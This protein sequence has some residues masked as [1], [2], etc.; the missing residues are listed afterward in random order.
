MDLPRSALSMGIENRKP[1]TRLVAAHFKTRRLMQVSLEN[2]RVAEIAAWP[3]DP[4]SAEPDLWICPGLVDLQVNGFGGIHFGDPAL[5]VDQ[6]QAVTRRLW[7]NGCTQ[8]LPTLIT[9][10]VDRMA[11][12]LVVLRRATEDREISNSILGFHLE[13]PYLSAEDGPRGAHPRE[14][15]K[16]PDW[17]E[18]CR[19]QD[20]AGGKIRLVTLAPERTGA[21]AFIAKAVA[22]G[23]RVAIGHTAA[24]HAQI[25][26]AVAAGAT[27][28][29]H[30]GNAAHDQL[31]RHHNYVFDQLAD[32]RLWASL[33]VDG[34]H[35][36]PQ[37]VKIFCRAKGFDRTIL[38][39]DAVQYAGLTPGI[40]D[41]G[42]CAIDVRADG[43][44]GVI[45]QPRL[46][47][48]GLLL[49]RGVENC[50]RFTGA[51]LADAIAAA[52]SN[53]AKYIGLHCRCDDAAYGVDDSLLLFRWDAQRQCINLMLTIVAGRVVHQ[54]D[55]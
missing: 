50:V 21:I 9:D 4:P 13:G 15:C 14:H 39:S 16:D 18:F 20:A 5:T 43:F 36:P 37:L 11:S 53:P 35:L 17:D 3:S 52:T 30:L 6:V 34:H 25:D 24:D 40:Y 28:A 22:N 32:D 26:D 33:I 46:A 29:T 48:S 47:G 12:A 51:A 10:S 1:L 31:Q 19:L 44:V 23:V 55:H 45:G 38:I 54:P 7:E 2:D 41:G 49:L 8:F 42:H 27:L